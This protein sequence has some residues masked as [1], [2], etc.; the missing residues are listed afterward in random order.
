M[1]P[2]LTR[3]PM[4]KLALVPWMAYSLANVDRTAHRII[5]PGRHQ[6]QRGL[7]S[8]AYSRRVFGGRNP[9]GP[10]CLRS[11]AVTQLRG[12]SRPPDRCRLA[13]LRRYYPLAGN[14]RGAFPRLMTIPSRT[15]SGRINCWGWLVLNRNAADIHQRRGCFQHIAQP[16][17]YWAG[18]TFQ[19]LGVVLRNGDGKCAAYQ[20]ASSGG[21]GWL[22]ASAYGWR[23]ASAPNR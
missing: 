11:T 8:F 2:R 22:T 4:P 9:V 23:A 21:S 15:V 19:R 18:K 1:H 16:R 7:P 20:T 5:R 6:R 12:V 17:P 14:N 13:G 10:S 3:S